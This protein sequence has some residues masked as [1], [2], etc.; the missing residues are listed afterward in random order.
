MQ[1]GAICFDKIREGLLKMI[2]IELL[3]EENFKRD[4][5]DNY[6]RKHDVK[7]YIVNTTENMS[8]SI[9]FTRRTGV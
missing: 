2:R 3:S 4:S 5:L 9:V 8:L 6:L 1:S 7:K